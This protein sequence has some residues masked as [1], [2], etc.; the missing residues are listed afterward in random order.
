MK[1]TTTTHVRAVCRLRT[2]TSQTKRKPVRQHTPVCSL[3]FE[4]VELADLLSVLGA[5]AW[6]N[7]P[8]LAQISQFTGLDPK[9]TRQLLKNGTV[10]GLL[11]SFDGELYSV[12]PPYP[13][14]GS[15]T[16]QRAVVRES[17][18]R[19]PLL[20]N[21]R[22]FLSMEDTLDA[23]LRKAAAVQRI[24]HFD[25]EQLA[26]LLKLARELKA[27][28]PDLALEDLYEEAEE[29]KG[30][31]NKNHP[32]KRVV[33]LSHNSKD[34]AMIRQITTDLTTAGICVWLHEQRVTAVESIPDKLAQGLVES[35]FFLVGLSEI[36]VKSAWAKTEFNQALLD[37][38]AIRGT[39]ILPLRL[40]DCVVP[41]IIAKKAFIDFTV[42]YKAGLHELLNCI[43]AEL[44]SVVDGAIEP[45][46]GG[47]LPPGTLVTER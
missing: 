6:L 39:R 2:K 20:A 37:E 38:V 34:N 21:V 46:A 12:V 23:A 45:V 8:D 42:S 27:L 44:A 16:Q 28:E 36:S 10:L 18:V 13:F 7:C 30:E 5:V 22:Q 15:I 11:E 24:E 40:T 3:R 14:K 26:P 43:K 19:M 47:V 9:T 25:P 4:T 41:E 33:F 29:A 35:D 32:K 31:R 17:L 1:N